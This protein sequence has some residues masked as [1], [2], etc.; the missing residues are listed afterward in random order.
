MKYF[1]PYGV[2]DPDAPYINGNPST[3]TMGSIPPGE[4]IEHDQREIVEV[5]NYANSHGYRDREGVPCEPPTDLDLTQLRKAIWGFIN[6]DKLSLNLDYYV[7]NTGSD[8]ANDGLTLATPFLTIQK[9]VDMAQ[10]FD[11]NGFV[12]T[13]HVADGTYAP[14]SCGSGVNLKGWGTLKVIGNITQP[15]QCLVTA[16]TSICAYFS[17]RARNYHCAGFKFV[18]TGVYPTGG[19]G[20]LFSEAFGYLYNCEF[21]ACSQFHMWSSNAY[22]ILCGMIDHVPNISYP[23]LI[24]SGPAGWHMRASEG[25]AI[26]CRSPDMTITQAI[27]MTGG[28]AL[29]DYLA[30]II[31][32]NDPYGSQP[33]FYNSLNGKANVA[34][35]VKYSAS[36]NSIIMSHNSGVGYFPCPGAGSVTTGGQYL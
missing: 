28:W 24:V 8:T 30:E 26:G 17:G 19:Y 4:S 12:I 34:G 35:G 29:A 23:M 11:P 25:G 31:C 6:A 13:V 18:N 2:T 9:A 1:Q 16:T 10:M 15:S 33:N 14:F 32:V 7:N 27:T 20:V 36:M 22:L 5:I 21:G 3:G